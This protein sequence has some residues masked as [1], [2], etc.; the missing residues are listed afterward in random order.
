M[1]PTMFSI[2]L[3]ATIYQYPLIA[4]NEDSI[5]NHIDGSWSPYEISSA[6]FNKGNIFDPW[7]LIQGRVPGVLIS[8]TGSNP[9]GDFSIR[10]RGH[11]TFQ[12]ANPNPMI[13]INGMPTNSLQGIDPADIESIKVLMDAEASRYG[14]R[15]GAGVVEVTTAQPTHQPVSFQW[16]SYMAFENAS[17]VP[18]LLN[19]AAYAR[20]LQNRWGEVRESNANT[21]WTDE[22]LQQAISMASN[23]SVSGG[24]RYLNYR[25]VINYRSVK[26]IQKFSGFDQINTNL[27]LSGRLM[28]DKL[29][30][31]LFAN[32]LKRDAKPGF[33]E[34][35]KYALIFDPTLAVKDVNSPYGGYSELPRF[36]TYNPVA[37]L[38]QSVRDR[39]LNASQI[40]GQIAYSPV[41]F[42]TLKGAYGYTND[43]HFEGTYFP[44]NAF[45]IGF[46]QNGFGSINE[47]ELSSH[48]SE[49]SLT[50]KFSLNQFFFNFEL[51]YNTQSFTRD[52]LYFQSG[53]VANSYDNTIQSIDFDYPGVDYEDGISLEKRQ[54]RAYYANA[55]IN[56]KRR[57]TVN[58]WNR[59]EGA[60][61]LGED[62][63]WHYF[64]GLRLGADLS[65]IVTFGF[66]DDLNL[67]A[68]IGKAG[69][70]PLQAG[71]SRA[72]YGPVG[73][74]FYNSE[75]I[76]SIVQIQRANNDLKYEKTIFRT[77]GFDFSALKKRLSGS[78]Q[79]F[80]NNA[81]DIIVEANRQYNRFPYSNKFINGHGIN[82]SGWEM[83]LFYNW[84]INDISLQ[85]SINMSRISSK[86]ENLNG[87]E[88]NLDQNLDG[89]I[90]GPGSS[91]LGNI[92]MLEGESVGT[93]YV[94][95]NLGIVGGLWVLEDGNNSGFPEIDDYTIA[96][97]G[98]P[99]NLLGISQSI[100]WKN[101]SFI[102]FLRGV[103]GHSMLNE[104]RFYHSTPESLRFNNV[105]TDYDLLN[106][107]DE[108]PR[109]SDY[110]VEKANFLSL[111]NLQIQYTFSRL[112][113]RVSKLSLFV[114]ANNLLTISTF[115]GSSPEPRLT[116]PGRYSQGLIRS[117]EDPTVLGFYRRTD[118]WSSRSIVFGISLGF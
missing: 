69:T 53:G 25:A 95:K 81:S 92:V 80:K 83:A 17:R 78:L 46:N 74:T 89:V 112:P 19:G 107:L 59:Y 2:L 110:F 77:I 18:Q 79:F 71:L 115:K 88:Y 24:S 12:Y 21:D 104:S 82:N 111:D 108:G 113:I 99:K 76:E 10:L 3:L 73:F 44:A 1:R 16:Q 40:N 114:A 54:I 67:T 26:G 90:Y 43:Q 84:A 9:N 50:S 15:G 61:V 97:Q 20:E 33:N 32:Y 29:S 91:S 7:Q 106:H 93:I 60:N 35:F 102:F 63:Q 101:W 13:V 94:P 75:I 68:S 117:M 37:I 11:S 48:F 85:T 8:K 118:W 86:F 64:P 96:G 98:F 36:D 28:D 66:L 105:Y 57:F 30:Y 49:I 22:I 55:T 109:L 51:G 72:L 14:V 103:F 38:E 47:E 116:D 4:Q 41:D 56:F 87:Q 70:L 34:A 5:A 58:V 100:A 62:N 31:S 23:F 6:S 45:H 65:S 27:S 52:E 42:L 39:T